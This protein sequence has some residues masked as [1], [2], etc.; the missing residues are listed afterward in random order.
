MTKK[1][2]GID[3]D[4]I[5]QIIVTKIQKN[6]HIYCF[7]YNENGNRSFDYKQETSSGYPSL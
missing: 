4:E 3:N 2:M 1:K 5:Y 6:K 7:L